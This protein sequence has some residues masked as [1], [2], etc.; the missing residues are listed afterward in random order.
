M[1]LLCVLDGFGL[2]EA[3]PDNAVAAANKPNYDWLVA[4]C[5]YNKI[6]GSGLAVGLPD[7]QMGNSEVGHLN[8]GAGRV[9]YQDVTRID[10][11]IADRDFASNPVFNEALERVV[12]DGRAVHL[13]GL[14]SDGLVHSS[15]DHLF[16]LTT[17]ARTKGVGE[18]YLH[19]FMDGRDTSPTGGK[20]YMAQVVKK[21]GEIGLGKVSTLGGRY[22]GMD[23]DKR[24]ERTDRA[25]RATVYGEGE[26]FEDPVKAIIASY[27]A[28]VTDE[29]IVPVVIDLGNPETGRLRDGDAAIFFNFRADRARQLCY[30]FLDYPIDG[31]SH[32]DNPEVELVTM[33]NYD[34]KMTDARVAFH[35]VNLDNILGGIISD[36][37]LR[38][39]RTAETEK[40]PH[41]TFFFN[42]GTEKP[43]EGEDRDLIPSPKVAT[44]DLKPE[45][46]SVEVTDNVVEKILSHTY[47]FI[48]I[49]YAN[50][51]MVGHTGVFDAARNAVEAVDRALGRL[52]EAVREVGGVALITS[53]HGNAEIMVDPEAGGP[54]TAHTT[55]LVPFILFDP[56]DRLKSDGRVSIRD[57]GILA[58]VAPTILDIMSI[59][60]PPEMTGASLIK[61]G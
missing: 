43:F 25:Y 47:D 29:F 14:V 5:P 26:K 34:A 45:M 11:A 33:T 57:G 31:Y 52:L 35:P 46:S 51:D 16:A 15:M 56:S 40:Y 49:N 37:G 36:R 7:G 50:C 27:E 30:M 24:W 38:Q 39:L 42:G 54:F 22:Y 9:V 3:T 20:D 53:D 19:A 41:V 60:P 10:K 18:L 4:N 59:P 2:R 44:Y 28:G 61:K 21:F 6:D 1:V 48:L 13:F 12:R 17:L 58:D 8:L 23:R 32:D 55:S